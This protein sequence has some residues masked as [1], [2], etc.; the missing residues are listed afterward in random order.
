MMASIRVPSC[1]IQF[2]RTTGH[3]LHPFYKR[4]VNCPTCRNKAFA[5]ASTTESKQKFLKGWIEI[6]AG[7][8]NRWGPKDGDRV[9]FVISAVNKRLGVKT[10]ARNSVTG[11][12]EKLKLWLQTGSIT[13]IEGMENEQ[14][15][16]VARVAL[17][18]ARCKVPPGMEFTARGIKTNRY[19][20]MGRRE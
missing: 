11:T 15:N 13:A 2:L 12:W 4:G 20:A 6:A 7:A 16:S 18:T 5:V 3:R 17:A 10:T 1:P 14:L 19:H 9:V 8:W